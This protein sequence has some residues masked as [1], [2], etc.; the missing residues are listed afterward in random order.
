LWLAIFFGAIFVVIGLGMLPKIQSTV[1]ARDAKIAADLEVAR[2][3]REAADG[4]EEGYRARMDKS[5]AEA[6]RLSA[7]AK[8]NATKSTEQS[9]AKADTVIVTKVDAAVASIGEAKA[10]AMSEIESVATEAV[11]GLVARVA[12][13]D[14]DADAARAAVAKELAHG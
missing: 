1:D 12:G 6:A 13:L 4:L 11:Q 9:V 5:R 10:K 8:A 7:E 2:G 14:V 3:A